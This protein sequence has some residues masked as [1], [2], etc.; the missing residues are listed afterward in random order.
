MRFGPFGAMALVALLSAA[1][2]RAETSVSVSRARVLLGDLVPN[3]APD[4]AS[5]DFGPAPPPGSSRL[6]A[7]AEIRRQ[8]AK[9]GV[10]AEKLKLPASVR[11]VS[12][13]RRFSPSE[14]A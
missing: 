8:L 6:V 9:S 14:I 5:L 12:A 13:A 2:T 7:G 1:S 11:V 4:V 3:L 10:G